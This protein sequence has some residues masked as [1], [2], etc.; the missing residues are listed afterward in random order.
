MHNP[1]KDRLSIIVKEGFIVHSIQIRS[2]QGHCIF[3]KEY[4]TFFYP[5]ERI[6]INEQ[7]QPR[8]LFFNGS[9][10]SGKYY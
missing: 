6:E 8:C 3:E 7:Q 4:S 2:L 5:E 9:Y 1:A 10:L